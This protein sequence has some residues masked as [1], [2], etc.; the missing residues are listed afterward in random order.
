MIKVAAPQERRPE[1]VHLAEVFRAQVVDLAPD[2][3][4]IEIT[5]G[6]ENIDGLLDVLR[7]FGVIEMARTGRVAMTRATRGAA[8]HGEPR[9]LLRTR[10]SQTFHTRSDDH[11]RTASFRLKAEAT[12]CGR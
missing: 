6:E 10:T 1:I 2:S 3:L 8:A 5:G 11:S 7:P 4:T 9:C 12:R